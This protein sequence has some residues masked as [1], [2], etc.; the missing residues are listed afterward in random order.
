M[1]TET[2]SAGTILHGMKA[3]ADFLGVNRRVAYH[4]AEARQIP[5]FKMGRSVCAMKAS[6]T[7]AIRDREA[8]AQL[9]KA[10][11]DGD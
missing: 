2:T 9:P 11:T 6:L 3:I 5:T 7:A 10:P 1:T 8:A 4:W